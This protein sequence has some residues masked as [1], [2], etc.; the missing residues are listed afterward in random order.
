VLLIAFVKEKLFFNKKRYSNSGKISK[1]KGCGLD[2]K[3]L[4]VIIGVKILLRDS[5]T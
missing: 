4:L 5:R 3:I 1:R 2:E